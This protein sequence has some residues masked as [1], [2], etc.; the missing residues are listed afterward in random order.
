MAGLASCFL[1]ISPWP[2]VGRGRLTVWFG[3]IA[4]SIGFLAIGTRAIEAQTGRVVP[5]GA[6]VQHVTVPLYHTRTLTIDKPFATAVIGAVEIADVLPLTD[7]S[8]Y[9]QG[10]KVGTTNV[11]IYDQSMRLVAVIDL[12][13]G[14]DAGNLQDKIRG[15]TR[16]SGIR[17]SSN[18][19]QVVLSGM[20]RDAVAADR[21]VQLAKSFAPEGTTVVNAMEVAPSQ[22]VM[23]KVRFLEV[24]R[25]ASRELGVNWFGAN[26]AGNR[27]VTTG[28]LS[29]NITGTRPATGG[30]DPNGNPVIG[31]GIPV[32][33]AAGTLL[34]GSQ[35]FGVALANLARNG[36]SIDVLISALETKGLV[37]SLAEPDLVA[38]SGDT[39]AFLAGGEFP[40][41]IAQPG[42]GNVPTITIEYKPFGVQLTFMPTVLANGVINLRLAPSV[43]ELDFAQA[44]VLSGFTIPSLIK[45]EARTTIELRDGQSFSIA[46]L[47]Q[48]DSK[49]NIS[50][51]PWIGS[52]P[53]L[54]ALFRSSEYQQDE[55]EL[56]VIVTPHLV[57]PAAPGDK[58][59]SPLDNRLIPS[60]DVDFFL[61]GQMELRKRA[62]DYVTVG[63]NLQGPYG[64][65]IVG[66]QGVNVVTTKD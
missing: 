66:T 22:Q 2:K 49:R 19:G 56:V 27:G 63:G 39:A 29:S 25:K 8:L 14:V 33:Q 45:R 3:I 53:V 46:G 18:A 28:L 64:H 40:V 24:N 30:V 44:V 12:E 16:S 31:A 62:E 11:S 65:M 5:E 55:T 36:G 38:L 52:V 34:S 43:S 17:V 50:Q 20:A 26:N 58:L 48:S 54:G 35:P 37:R 61:M 10:K 32:F 57:R 13:V 41:P 47:L 6:T 7:R 51:L 21:A 4:A 9:V 15:G 59:A 1:R 60:N 42:S 23:L